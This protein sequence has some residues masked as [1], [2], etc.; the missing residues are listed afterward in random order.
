MILT[1]ARGGHYGNGSPAASMEHAETYLRSLLHFWASGSRGRRRG[2]VGDRF[3]AA[4]RRH[5]PSPRRDRQS[6]GGLRP[7]EA[8][9]TAK[10]CTRR[11]AAIEGTTSRGSPESGTGNRRVRAP[12]PPADSPLG[13]FFEAKNAARLTVT[14]ETDRKCNIRC[15]LRLRAASAS[16][17]APGCGGISCRLTDRRET[18]ALDLDHG[19][20]LCS[21]SV[22]QRRHRWG[23]PG[24]A[25]RR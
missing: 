15:I 22:R 18:S 20:R 24:I 9:A 6:Q 11:L 19:L 21:R 4:R 16:M 23:W 12:S 2:R 7:E 3:P 17:S 25:R 8:E 1:I 5:P 13:A 14:L 10:I